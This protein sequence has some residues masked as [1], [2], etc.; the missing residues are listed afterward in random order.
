MCSMNPNKFA[1]FSLVELMV[2]LVIGLIIILGA[3]QLFLTSSQNFRAA[4]DLSRTS[5]DVFFF[6]DYLVKDFRR[7]SIPIDFLLEQSGGRYSGVD[8]TFFGDG[9]QDGWCPPG[10]NMKKK[11]LVFHE[12]A[13]FMKVACDDVD[14]EEFP[15]LPELDLADLDVSNLSGQGYVVLFRGLSPGGSYF[16]ERT[17]SYEVEVGVGYNSELGVTRNFVFTAAVRSGIVSEYE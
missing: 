6:S 3:G 2:A 9:V 5:S 8:L 17:N 11:R 16:L 1:G 4:Q 15:S 14:A 13:L 12:D 7:A 10:E